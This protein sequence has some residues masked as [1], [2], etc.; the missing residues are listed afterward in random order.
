M[1]TKAFIFLRGPGHCSPP[2]G[3]L[4]SRIFYTSTRGD[5]HPRKSV[6]VTPMG[7][8]LKTL[9]L[10]GREKLRFAVQIRRYGKFHANFP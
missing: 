5:D 4:L 7:L 3:P 1:R 9:G 8:E 10:A 2:I 6:L